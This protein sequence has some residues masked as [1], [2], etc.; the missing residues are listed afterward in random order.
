MEEQVSRLYKRKTLKKI[1][2]FLKYG[3]KENS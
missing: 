2:S 1:R 3:L